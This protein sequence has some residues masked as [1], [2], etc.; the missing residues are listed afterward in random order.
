MPTLSRVLRELH[1]SQIIAGLQTLSYG[2][3][4]LWLGDAMN[5]TSPPQRLNALVE[6][7]WKRTWLVGCTRPR[8]GIFRIAKEHSTEAPTK[9]AQD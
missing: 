5:A 7:G 1:D 3:V 2:G 9:A 8:Y 4:R 6:S